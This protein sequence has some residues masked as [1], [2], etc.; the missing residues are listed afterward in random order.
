MTKKEFIDKYLHGYRITENVKE[1]T[2]LICPQNENSNK[3]E[4]A[5]V[6]NITIK[7]YDDFI[8]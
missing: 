6:H 8:V 3:I 5:R 2:L 7:F 1:A 4:Y